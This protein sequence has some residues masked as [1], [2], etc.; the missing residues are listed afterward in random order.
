MELKNPLTKK[1]LKDVSVKDATTIE[2]DILGV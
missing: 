2:I 1:K